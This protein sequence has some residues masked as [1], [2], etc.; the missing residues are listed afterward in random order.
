M[1]IYRKLWRKEK[2]KEEESYSEKTC[3]ISRWSAGDFRRPTAGANSVH[4]WLHRTHAQDVTGV[5]E[6]NDASFFRLEVL[7]MDDLPISVSIRHNT[8][9]VMKLDTCIINT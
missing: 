6:L 7:K 4:V 9:V 3:S 2:W 1:N 8:Y 5:S